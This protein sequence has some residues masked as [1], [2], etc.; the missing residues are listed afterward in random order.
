MRKELA[1]GA[2]LTLTQ[3]QW[4]T[5]NNDA[6]MLEQK[7]AELV[8]E[9]ENKH[10]PIQVNVLTRKRPFGD[11]YNLKKGGAAQIKLHD[12]TG[13]GTSYPVT[14]IS[15][16]IS[17]KQLKVIYTTNQDGSELT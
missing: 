1:P 17:E 9:F 15:D 7:I 4:D 5:A 10:I 12:C 6:I 13:L 2:L 16:Y 8:E 3:S 11:L 14:I